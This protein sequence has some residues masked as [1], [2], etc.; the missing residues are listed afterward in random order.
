MK[1]TE[2][3]TNF[4]KVGFVEK[5]SFNDRLSNIQ[6]STRFPAYFKNLLQISSC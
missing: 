2:G 5:E 4:G 1:L 3:M 6:C